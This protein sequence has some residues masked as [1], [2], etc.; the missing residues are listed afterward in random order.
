M[1]KKKISK[2]NKLAAQKKVVEEASQLLIRLLAAGLGN[3]TAKRKL[4]EAFPTVDF[5]RCLLET[6]CHFIGQAEMQRAIIAGQSMAMLHAAFQLAAQKNNPSAMISAA[7][8]RE[9]VHRKYHEEKSRGAI[10]P[11]ESP[12]WV[13]AEEK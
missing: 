6:Y 12:P 8:G 13:A 4:L 3:E 10:D 7:K 9:E 11:I 1:S 5:E 2:S